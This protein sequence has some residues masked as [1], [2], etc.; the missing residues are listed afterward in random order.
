MLTPGGPPHLNALVAKLQ[1]LLAGDRNPALATDP[2]LNYMDAAEVQL[3][4]ESLP[5]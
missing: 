1:S 4:L 2:E 3:L 5:S